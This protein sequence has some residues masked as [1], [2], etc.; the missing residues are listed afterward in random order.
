MVNS[1]AVKLDQTG[2]EDDE[3]MAEGTEETRFSSLAATLYYRTS[4]QRGDDFGLHE[5]GQVEC[6]I[7]CKEHVHEEG[8]SDTRKR[9]RKACIFLRGVE[10]VTW[11]KTA[12]ERDEETLVD[13][14][15]DSAWA[16]PPERKST[17][18]GMKIMMI[19]GTVL[20][21]CERRVRY[22]QRKPNLMQWLQGRRKVLGRIQ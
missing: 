10:K 20:A 6:A 9:L 21:Q 3:E 2:Q 13:V 5:P 17:R 1:V 7:R 14:Y 19:N 22:G 11:A 12:W 4:Q 15:V 16:E 8:E 18:G